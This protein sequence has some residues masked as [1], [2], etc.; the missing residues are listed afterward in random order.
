MHDPLLDSQSYLWVCLCCGHP[1]S[2]HVSE[3]GFNIS[4]GKCMWNCD[5]L[6][7]FAWNQPKDTI[8]RSKEIFK[9][10]K[11]IAVHSMSI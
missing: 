1:W 4:I 11:E 6:E 8:K 5:K 3:T 7:T 2:T 9:C 10:T